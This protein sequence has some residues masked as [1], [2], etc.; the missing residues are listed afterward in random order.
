MS[1]RSRLIT[2]AVC[3]VL[4]VG[5]AAATTSA[6]AATPKARNATQVRTAAG[7]QA[8]LAVPSTSYGAGYF[9][10]PGSGDVAS[11]SV[12]FTMPAFSCAHTT[13]SEWLSPGIWVFD[14]SGALSQFSG[15]QF[16]CNDGAL[17]QGDVMCVD[18]YAVCDD[19]LTVQPGDRVVSTLYESSAQT[20][21]AFHDLTSGGTIRISS[22]P[23]TDDYT[24][25]IGDLGPSIA[26][27]GAVT[28]VPTFLQV[29]FSKAQVNGY[30]LGDWG[31]TR[32]NLKTSLALQERGG[33]LSGDG[34]AF[35]TT[36]VHN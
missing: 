8:S 18:D 28:R 13:D 12:T 21:A 7:L 16:N 9:S 2:T 4:A 22:A 19:S 10:Y 36:F 24:V 34:D 31:P 29:A 15:V 23:V 26:S 33:A 14:N 3:A 25:F 17:F 32:Y 6:R 20:V 30:Y 27:S 1:V 5:F 35:K 11:A